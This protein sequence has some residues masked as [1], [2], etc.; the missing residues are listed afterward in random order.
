M[1]G[2]MVVDGS[3]PLVAQR[4]CLPGGDTWEVGVCR[5][6]G[7]GKRGR[8]LIPVRG[9]GHFLPPTQQETNVCCCILSSTDRQ[10]AR[11]GRGA[12]P[13][14]LLLGPHSTWEN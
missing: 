4:A 1:V 11:R 10:D 6:V 2:K 12:D 3:G 5:G 9:L 8:K 14:G 13:L 7:G